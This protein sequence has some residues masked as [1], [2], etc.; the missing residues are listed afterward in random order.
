[1]FP[2]R[3]YAPDPM[4]VPSSSV[5][6]AL[7]SVYQMGFAFCQFGLELEYLVKDALRNHGLKSLAR[8][9]N[10]LKGLRKGWHGKVTCGNFGASLL[11]AHGLLQLLKLHIALISADLGSRLQASLSTNHENI[12]VPSWVTSLV[13]LVGSSKVRLL[14]PNM[15]F[16]YSE[17]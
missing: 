14:E 16:R 13:A 17:Q 7:P 9:P 6:I 15:P 5:L 10:L 4:L 1:M 11:V 2:S 3:R 12:H 8:T